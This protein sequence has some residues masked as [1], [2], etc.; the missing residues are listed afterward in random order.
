MYALIK[1]LAE[2]DDPT[3]NPD[4]PQEMATIATTDWQ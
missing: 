4:Y 3:L 2:H 1:Q